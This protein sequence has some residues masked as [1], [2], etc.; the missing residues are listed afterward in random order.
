MTSKR[1][2]ADSGA[3]SPDQL[4]ERCE[5]YAARVGL[6]LSLHRTGKLTGSIYDKPPVPPRAF[7][8]RFGSLPDGTPDWLLECVWNWKHAGGESEFSLHLG[9][10]Q[11]RALAT[12]LLNW[13]ESADAVRLADRP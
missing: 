1:P 3:E 7:S 10:A 11:A 2:P 9:I 8:H 13:A 12:A 4:R 6:C 5:R